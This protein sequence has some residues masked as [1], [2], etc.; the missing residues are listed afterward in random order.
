MDRSPAK[1][2]R[3][4]PGSHLPIHAPGHILAE[5]PDYVL[6][7]PWNLAAEI[8]RQ[9]AEVRAYGGKFVVAMPRVEVRTTE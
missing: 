1:Q 2:G 5:R 7:L 8:T 3:V 4:L 9:L 6:V